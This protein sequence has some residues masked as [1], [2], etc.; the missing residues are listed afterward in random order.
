MSKRSAFLTLAACFSCLVAIGAQS[1][2]VQGR[3][4]GLD[5]V[6]LPEGNGKGLVQTACSE[7]H[8]L[9]QVANSGGYDHQGWQ[10]T[11]ERMVTDGAKI[12]AN[13]IGVVVDYLTS[14]FPEQPRPPAVVIPGA[15]RV[16]IKEWD[17]PT[18]GSR[19]HDPLATPDG[20]IWYTG[21]YANVLGRLDPRTGQFKEYPLNTAKSGPHGLTADKAGNV[22]F[23]AN[24]KGYVG[25]LDPKSGEIIEYQMPDPS[26]RDPH[27][28]IFDQKGNL[29]FTLQNSNMIGRLDPR[30][31]VIK[32][33]TSPTARSNPYGMVVNSKGV[34]FLV[35]F[36]TN[37]VASLD[38]D[39]MA[40]REY[41]L[42]NAD[43]RPRRIAITSDDVIW[44]S[45]YSR[46]YLG[47]L[48]PMSGKVTE[49]PSPG[50]PRSQPY[51]ITA[52]HDV[53]WYSESAVKPNTLVRFDPKTEKFQ[54]WIIPSG[55]GVVRNMMTTRDGNLVMAESGVNKVAL[56][57][58]MK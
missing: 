22:W 7:C 28:P 4:G 6:T 5:Q 43:S 10:L 35:D 50:G 48:D 15:A 21:M 32:L 37:K 51:G 53:I 24:S 12:P 54:T 39:T 29:W 2:A 45:D 16:S 18:K 3:G 11:V 38:P 40:I 36:G 44:Y 1:P 26:A 42:P 14:A 47:R 23:T 57:E 8:G 34:P 25:K 17:V 19:P 52:L 55:G 56:V 20:M 46:G 13:Q 30:T 9:G 49:W 41:P 27:T 31:G 33:V 58:V